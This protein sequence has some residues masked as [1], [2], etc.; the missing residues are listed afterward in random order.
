ME[1]KSKL[2]DNPEK[3]TTSTSSGT[4]SNRVSNRS[5]L[6]NFTQ[7]GNPS[8][9]AVTNVP[10]EY[11]EIDAD[12]EMGTNMCA[13]FLSLRYHSLN[14]D[15]IH[16][17]LKKLGNK[18]ELRVLLVLVDVKDPHH[19]IKNLTRICILADMTLVLAWSPEEAGKILETYKIYENKPADNLMEKSESSPYLVLIQ[20]LSSIKPVNKTDAMT[21]IAKF[22]TLEGI[23]NAN[24]YQ[25]SECP[26][27]GPRKAKKLYV[28]LHEKFCR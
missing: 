15:Y 9:K 17:R 4:S 20:A 22:K 3:P 12:Y 8:L 7:R 14:Q 27:F 25:L 13:L 10:W 28:T 16:S 21:L 1:V 11:G 24:E 23:L 26:G 2:T 6:V 18:Y 19:H 5:L